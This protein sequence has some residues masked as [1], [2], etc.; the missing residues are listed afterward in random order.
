MGKI[1]AKQAAFVREYLVDLNATK[2]AV[3]AGYSAKTANEQA[4]RLLAKVSISQVIAKLQSERAEKTGRTALDVLTDIQNVTKD[5][6][7]EG[8]FKTAL[9]G[10]E[11][12]GK[13]LG[14]FVDRVDLSNPDGTLKPA[15]INLSHL[16]VDDLLQ[17]SRNVFGKQE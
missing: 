10:L 1:T 15:V 13:H 16:S 8:D 2:A 11:M 12:E 4:A 5:A 9:K 17:L 6:R 3:R 14:M 7:S